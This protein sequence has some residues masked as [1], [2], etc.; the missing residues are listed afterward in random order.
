MEPA[1]FGFPDHLFAEFNRRARRKS[2]SSYK[3]RRAAAAAAEKTE[4]QAR[5]ARQQEADDQVGR[6]HV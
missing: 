3:L 4:D 6:Y 5:F 1:P 2:G